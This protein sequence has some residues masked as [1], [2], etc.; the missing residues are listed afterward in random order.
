MTNGKIMNFV[1]IF[2]DATTMLQRLLI[3]R[4]REVKPL[5][6]FTLVLSDMRVLSGHQN[7]KPVA[8]EVF[9]KPITHGNYLHPFDKVTMLLFKREASKVA[10]QSLEIDK[11]GIYI[12]VNKK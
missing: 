5:D 10:R 11:S 2:L 4:L 8:L 7:H 9:Y 1:F 12:L 3:E 6:K